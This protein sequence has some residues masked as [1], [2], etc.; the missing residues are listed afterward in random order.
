MTALTK[1]DQVILG[2]KLRGAPRALVPDASISCFVNHSLSFN[3][4][5]DLK[6]SLE[7][8]NDDSSSDSQQITA[9]M[10]KSTIVAINN[11]SE[12]SN[13]KPISLRS[14]QGMSLYHQT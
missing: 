10:S 5:Q 9:T 14:D 12:A 6:L 13:S 2:W 1:P 3:E 4:I 11:T 8:C 7:E